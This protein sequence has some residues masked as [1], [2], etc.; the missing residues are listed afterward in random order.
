MESRTRNRHTQ[1]YPVTSSEM[2]VVQQLFSALKTGFAKENY[3]NCMGGG[4]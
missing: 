1:L 4:E 3:E 2:D